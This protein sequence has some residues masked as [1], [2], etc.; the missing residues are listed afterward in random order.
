[1]RSVR[2][3]CQFRTSIILLPAL[4]AAPVLSSAA[5]PEATIT[6][7]SADGGMTPARRQLMDSA[8]QEP[9]KIAAAVVAADLPAPQLIVQV[10]AFQGEFLETFLDQFPAARGQWVEAITSE[11]NLP[12]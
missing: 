9:R 7:A 10:G 2:R 12:D 4:I 3:L 5:R 6:A 8:L 1:M 11:H